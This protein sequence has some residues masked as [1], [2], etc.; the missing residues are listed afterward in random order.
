[1]IPQWDGNPTTMIDYIM[2]ITLLAQLSKRLFKEIGQIAPIRWTGSAKGW[3][4]TLPR[5]DQAYFL[6]DWECLMTGMRDHFMNDEWLNDRGIEFD[7]MRFRRGHLHSRET[8][9]E[10]FNRRI[11]L[12][13]VLHPGEIDGPTVTHRLM[14]R[15]PI[16]WSS[17]LNTVSCPSI[18]QLIKLAKAMEANLI[19]QYYNG[20][21]IEKS[22]SVH[23]V[24]AASPED[25]DKSAGEAGP[26]E[27]KEAQVVSKGGPRKCTDWPKGRTIAGYSY[28]QDDSVISKVAPPGP[29]FICLSPKHFFRDCP[30][31][32]RFFTKSAHSVDIVV[33][34]EELRDLDL[35]YYNLISTAMASS[36]AYE[37]PEVELGSIVVDEVLDKRNR[38]ERRCDKFNM[39]SNKKGKH[40]MEDLPRDNRATRCQLKLHKLAAVACIDETLEQLDVPSE[41][42]RLFSD[43]EDIVNYPDPPSDGEDSPISITDSTYSSSSSSPSSSVSSLP[44]PS[45]KKSESRK[46]TVEEVDDPEAP[47][48]SKDSTK[49]S[50]ETGQEEFIPKVPEII[51]AAKKE[52]KPEGLGSLGTQALHIKAHVQSIGK[53]EVK[54]RLDSGADITLMSEEFWKQL[55]ILPKPKEGMRMKLYHLTGHAKVLGYVKTR[56]YTLTK[57]NVWIGFELEAYIVQGMRVPLL[58]GEDFQTAYKL[59]V[60]CYA[61]GNCEVTVS[62]DTKVIPTSSAHDVDLGFEIRQ[63]YLTQ[64]FVRAKTARRRHTRELKKMPKELSPVYAKEDVRVEPGTV[65]AV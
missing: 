30:H 23:A 47:S 4:M 12:H 41:E 9:E 33:D 3:W 32:V 1:M 7:A 10:Y 52:N 49:H 26:S 13:M 38:N 37:P 55:G 50:L 46:A 65:K 36:S 15:Q 58:L 11:R 27:M 24:E 25:S 34:Q 59:H 53:G 28:S 19:A 5:A 6:Q 21:R 61:T 8:P 2:E 35:E 48:I 17:I 16:L 18:V 54:A 43:E 14:N 62:N 63:S 64:S 57:D 51:M 31:N 22:K 56:L 45:I 29:C 39:K 42:E 40:K 20:L 60:K 44:L